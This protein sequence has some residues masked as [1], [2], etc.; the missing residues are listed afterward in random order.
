MRGTAIIAAIASLV[1]T[2]VTTGNEPRAT[3]AGR[4][5]TYYIA[6]EETTWDYAPA[7][8]DHVLAA[9]SQL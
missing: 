3:P 6:A 5:R 7:G 2:I 1:M 4:T 9:P 8:R